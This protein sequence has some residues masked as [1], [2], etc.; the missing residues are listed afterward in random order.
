MAN[1]FARQLRK[2]MTP[3]EAKLWVQL[4]ELRA[5]DLHFRRQSPIDGYIVDFVCF[6]SRVIVEIDGG[7]HAI[8]TNQDRARDE[9]FERNGFRVLRFWNSDVDLN[10]D[11][12]IE[13][14]H[15]ACQVPHPGALRAPTHPAR[16]RD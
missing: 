2:R 10:L 14:I 13:T 7:Q 11:G 15:R 3:Q 8:N 9:H 4:R 5:H 16:G 12:V 6:G 1:A